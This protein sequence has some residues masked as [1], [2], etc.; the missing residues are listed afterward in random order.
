M[1]SVS[2]YT[3]A[4]CAVELLAGDTIE[5]PLLNHTQL[6]SQWHLFTQSPLSTTQNSHHN[7]SVHLRRF[8]S[9]AAEL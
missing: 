5:P 8:K 9:P 6:A 2:V 7:K 3:Q 1:F 4:R